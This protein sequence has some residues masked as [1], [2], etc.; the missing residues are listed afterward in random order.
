MHGHIRLAADSSV[1]RKV[2]TDVIDNMGL[3]QESCSIE[4]LRA[5]TLCLG[6]IVMEMSEDD[7][8]LG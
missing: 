2:V 6:S 3:E 7:D 8:E 5:H 4:S 1:F